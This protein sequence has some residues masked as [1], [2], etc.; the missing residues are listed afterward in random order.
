MRSSPWQS[1]LQRSPSSMCVWGKSGTDIPAVSFSPTRG[2]TTTRLQS[3]LSTWLKLFHVENR[4]ELSSLYSASYLSGWQYQSEAGVGRGL[5][6]LLL[7]LHLRP[8]SH[9][10]QLPGVPIVQCKSS[11]H[12]EYFVMSI[13]HNVLLG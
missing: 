5:L 10:P 1:R 11:P 13:G 8:C 4:S 12:M 2:R 7:L 3:S 9:Q 6:S